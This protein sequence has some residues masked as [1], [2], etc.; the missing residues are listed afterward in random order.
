MYLWSQTQDMPLTPGIQ[1]T[2]SNNKFNK[3]VMMSGVSFG[4]LQWINYFQ[5]TDFL[6][7]NHGN[8]IQI[9]HAYHRGGK[10]IE[11]FSFDGYFERNGLKY[12]MEYNGK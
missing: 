10:K 7:D 11:G 1:W 12:F 3:S 6:L 8:R 5:A 4:Q 2:K 9:E